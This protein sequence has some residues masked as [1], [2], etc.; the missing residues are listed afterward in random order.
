MLIAVFGGKGVGKSTFIQNSL[1][2]IKNLYSLHFFLL[3]PSFFLL[4]YCLSFFLPPP[5][6][7]IMRENL[8]QGTSFILLGVLAC[9]GGM[10]P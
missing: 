1:V 4:H 7:A 8:R 5:P 9:A 3:L 6:R 2:C 10:F